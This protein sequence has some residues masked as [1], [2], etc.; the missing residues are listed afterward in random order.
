[1][2]SLLLLLLPQ[3][4]YRVQLYSEGARGLAVHFDALENVQDGQLF[5]SFVDSADRQAV[6]IPQD[7]DHEKSGMLTQ[8]VPGRPS[9]EWVGSEEQAALA[10]A[11]ID[12]LVHD[13]VGVTALL[14]S[15]TQATVVFPTYN[16]ANE[17]T[18]DALCSQ[19]AGY[20]S[21]SFRRAILFRYNAN[22]YATCSGVMMNSS[23]KT[24]LN[25]CFQPSSASNSVVPDG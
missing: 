2:M 6:R 17:C 15:A 23:P 19:G 3:V 24:V 18:N 4:T 21:T 11:H 14:K 20:R 13:A 10:K 22:V 12:H 8:Y 5:L 7:F 1:M 16:I 25:I 9:F